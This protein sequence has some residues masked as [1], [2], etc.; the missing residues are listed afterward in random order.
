[1]VVYWKPYFELNLTILNLVTSNN[2]KTLH[3][4]FHNFRY[5]C[6]RSPGVY[7]TN[8]LRATFT[9]QIP[10]AQKDD[11]DPNSTNL[12][13]LHKHNIFNFSILF[14]IN[15]FLSYVTQAKT[16]K[17]QKTKKNKV[18]K[19]WLM[20]LKLSSN[21][22]FWLFWNDLKKSCLVWKIYEAL[23]LEIGIFKTIFFSS[24]SFQVLSWGLKYAI[25]FLVL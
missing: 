9:P 8:V 3:L 4:Y 1:M 22:I 16:P 14:Y 19:D 18:W 10:K 5:D 15:T 21:S 23:K 17:H 20:G 24:F 2:I 6:L 7:F 25:S 12:L 13:F 11:I